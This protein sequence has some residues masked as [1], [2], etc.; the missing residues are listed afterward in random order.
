M[1]GV[2]NV[3]ALPLSLSL[4]DALSRLMDT[5]WRKHG[6]AFI[7]HAG[8]LPLPE[9]PCG[10]VRRGTMFPLSWWMLFP[11]ETTSYQ[12]PLSLFSFLELRSCSKAAAL[13][14][15]HV[16]DTLCKRADF[17]SELALASF[18]L[19]SVDGEYLW[20]SHVD[21]GTV[22]FSTLY[23]DTVSLRSWP[24]HLSGVLF[25]ST[26][27]LKTLQLRCWCAGWRNNILTRRWKSFRNSPFPR[28]A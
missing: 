9:S 19:P 5:L 4:G 3:R 14:R 20:P 15:Q 10:H 2:N 6:A 21:P 27:F 11:H 16:F 26:S 7:T 13:Q 18:L 1:C 22:P 8:W 17:S 25:F 28:V 24:R 23:L 12:K